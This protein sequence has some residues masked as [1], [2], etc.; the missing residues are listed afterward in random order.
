MQDMSSSSWQRRGSSVVFHSTLLGPLIVEGHLV[1]LWKALGWLNHW[2]AEPPAR[3][4]TVL[5][6]GLEACLEL[7][8]LEEGKQFLKARIKPFILEFQHH[9]DQR[10]LVFGF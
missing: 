10:G 8:S 3:G 2:P 9:W 5:V 7:L 1:S 6:G 4:A